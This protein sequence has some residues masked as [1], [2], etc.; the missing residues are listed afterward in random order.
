MLVHRPSGLFLTRSRCPSPPLPQQLSFAVGDVLLLRPVDRC[1]NQWTYGS[2]DGLGTEGYFPLSYVE[3]VQPPTPAVPLAP[4]STTTQTVPMDVDEFLMQ[5]SETAAAA[6]KKSAPSVV[7]R[8][9]ATRVDDDIDAFLKEE[10]GEI[11]SEHVARNE[12][13][14]EI[15]EVPPVVAAEKAVKPHAQVHMQGHVERDDATIRLK[16]EFKGDPTKRQLHVAKNGYVTIIRFYKLGWSF[17]KCLQTGETGFVPNNYLEREPPE[18]L[19]NIEWRV[20]DACVGLRG[21]NQWSAAR[22]RSVFEK[23]CLVAFTDDNFEMTLPSL[24][25]IPD[26]TRAPVM[27]SPVNAEAGTPVSVSGSSGDGVDAKSSPSSLK[28]A[29]A[30]APILEKGGAESEKLWAMLQSK[31]GSVRTSHARAA[32]T[33]VAVVGTR[34]T[35]GHGDGF[36]IGS[37]VWVKSN[38]HWFSGEVVGV[39][40]AQYE[41]IANGLMYV[42]QHEELRPRKL[43]PVAKPLASNIEAAERSPLA[44]RFSMT[45]DQ[46]PVANASPHPDSTRSLRS[47]SVSAPTSR[48]S[49]TSTSSQVVVDDAKSRLLLTEALDESNAALIFIC[50]SRICFLC[51]FCAFSLTPC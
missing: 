11:L 45:R 31:V 42:A 43:D 14:L 22:I 12:E 4:A 49:Q 17:A 32:P 5:V 41:V 44:R 3:L 30:E 27:A 24:S 28:P 21:P 37:A 23:G 40:G 16:W 46:S 19:A 18:R 10:M 13:E 35:P 9:D 1:P 50:L 34:A 48:S 20:G 39:A 26:T 8:H 51:L 2:K 7:D 6:N 25:L 47:S 15:F 38:E 33:S 29:K 36:P